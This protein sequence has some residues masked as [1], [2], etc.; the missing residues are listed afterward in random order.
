MCGPMSNTTSRLQVQEKKLRA[1]YRRNHPRIP[2][3]FNSGVGDG[4]SPVVPLVEQSLA[5]EVAGHVGGGGPRLGGGPPLPAAGGGGRLEQ[6]LLNGSELDGGGGV[7]ERLH[8]VGCRC[9][10]WACP[11]CGVAYW[12]RVRRRVM[13]YAPWFTRPAILTFT[14]DPK[15]FSGPEAAFEYVRRGG[16]LRRL[17]RLLGFKK[18]FIVMAFHPNRPEWVHWHVVVD[19]A[20]LPGGRFDFGRVWALWRDKWK[21]GGW[22]ASWNKGKQ[23][24]DGKQAFGYAVGYCQHQ[25]GVVAEWALRRKRLPRAY[26]FC[27]SLRSGIIFF[28]S[29]QAESDD[30][31]AVPVSDGVESAVVRAR[32]ESVTVSQRVARCGGG[33]NLVRELEYPDGKK[34]FKWVGSLPGDVRDYIHVARQGGIVGARVYVPEGKVRGGFVES[35]LVVD[36]C[37]SDIV[38]DLKRAAASLVMSKCSGAWDGGARARADAA[39]VLRESEALSAAESPVGVPSVEY[40]DDGLAPF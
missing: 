39:A 21:I 18:A 23:Y 15:N 30:E 3:L 17:M 26:E 16:Y 37:S 12:G 20:D 32:A 38:D 40:L 36:G 24:R 28:E 8:V 5:S 22:D 4:E 1:R 2:G 35:R 6:E 29:L 11:T 13:A 19:M 27:G 34:Y 10:S 25:S 14:M 31:G 33:V 7:V 9:K